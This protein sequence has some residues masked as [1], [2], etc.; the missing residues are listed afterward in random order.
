MYSAQQLTLPH[1]LVTVQAAY[2][3][4]AD[5]AHEDTLRVNP[6][7]TKETLREASRTRRQLFSTPMKTLPMVFG[8]FIAMWVV[9]YIST[10]STPMLI[11]VSI[12]S[13]V[14]M[15]AYAI[16][17]ITNTL[18]KYFFK[19]DNVAAGLLRSNDGRTLLERGHELTLMQKN[20]AA[21][22]QALDLIY[23]QS[24][25]DDPEANKLE[26]SSLDELCRFVET[27]DASIKGLQQQLHKAQVDL[28]AIPYET[29]GMRNPWTQK[30]IDRIR[31]ISNQAAHL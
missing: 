10:P 4:K 29:A 3:T 30:R 1:L 7:H 26:Q 12:V 6:F 13:G 22:Q 9:N 18:Y 11:L 31:T 24:E 25:S 17:E 20:Q 14:G 5:M 15:G 16:Y 28:L 23:E 2:N 27:Q 19:F 21:L 8:Y